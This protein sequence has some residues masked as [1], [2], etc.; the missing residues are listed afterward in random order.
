MI[1]LCWVNLPFGQN[2]PT[3]LKF[4]VSMYFAIT[5]KDWG[6][7]APGE[8]PTAYILILPDTAL[9][10]HVDCDHGIAAQTMLPGAREKGL[11]GC[12]IGAVRAT[13]LLNSTGMRKAGATRPRGRSLKS[14]SKFKD[15]VASFFDFQG[16]GSARAPTPGGIS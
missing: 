10:R 7:P 16:L 2:H 13:E 3:Y 5:S 6:G 9:A 8:R 4:V 15:A 11:A 14:L 1:P 12:M